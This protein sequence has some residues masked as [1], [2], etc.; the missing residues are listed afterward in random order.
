[1]SGKTIILLADGT[2]NGA[3]KLFKTNVWRLYKA[4]DLSEPPP[5][6]AKQQ[7]AYYH[8]GVGTSTFKPLAI[9]GGVFGFG[10]KRNVLHMYKFLCR[11][12]EPGDRIFVYGFSR[13][14]F[15]A[16][17]LSGVITTQGILSCPTE[18][19]LH[20]YAP[21]AYRWYRRRYKLPIF[22]YKDK[23]AATNPNRTVGLVDWLR[24]ARD[25]VLKAW[26]AAW[27]YKQYDSIRG[28]KY[29]ETFL[30]TDVNVD[31]IGV[32]D[33]VAAYGLPIDELTRGID[34]WVWPLSMPDYELS[35]RVLQARHA[36]S[37]DDERDTFHPLLWDEVAEADLVK[38]KLVKEGRLLQVWFAGMHSN[39]GGGYADD[40]LSYGALEWM[41][42]ESGKAGLFFLPQN[43]REAP[44]PR[45][46]F[47]TLYNSRSGV[48]AYYRYQP[49]K[50]AARLEHPDKTTLMMQ[51]PNRNGVGFL[52]TVTVHESVLHRVGTGDDCYAPIVLP[53]D[54]RVLQSNGTIVPGGLPKPVPAAPGATS[55]TEWVWNDVWRRRVNYF[56]T[57]GVSLVLA[58]LPLFH[59]LWP[60][61]ACSGPQCLL[62]PVITTAGE[63]LPGFVQPWIRAFSVSP[64]FFLLLALFIVLLLARSAYLKRCIQDGMRELWVEA[65]KLRK[66]TGP[67]PVTYAGRFP[68]G[69]RGGIY[70]LRSNRA[71]QTFFQWLKW[72]T[73]PGLFG[74]L[75]LI[76]GALIAV[77]LVVI[78]LQRSGMA[79]AERS[80]RYCEPGAATFSTA[81][82]CWVS[83]VDVKKGKRYVV[84]MRVT[85]DWLDSSPWLD[86]VVRTSPA[87]YEGGEMRWFA[88]WLVLARRSLTGRW[89]QVMARVIPSENQPSDWWLIRQWQRVFSPQKDGSGA[90][91]MGRGGHT[92]LLDMRCNCAQGPVYSAEFEAQRDGRVALFVNDAM[93]LWWPFTLLKPLDQDFYAN[94][95]GAAEVTIAQ[96]P[97]TPQ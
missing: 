74:A 95:Q 9:L 84:T 86:G 28:K 61:T 43:M 65:L 38:R 1:M 22:G 13:G 60:P 87:G 27:R 39:V 96:V 97:D 46:D 66:A 19:E 41:M 57:V 79:L 53:D 54:F 42:A 4:L 94:N 31:F 90:W 77:S 49:R 2:G 64:G 91:T 14:A 35:P 18:E 47:G 7:M 26:R 67:K 71:Y 50:I 73:L 44:T 24:N 63:F 52:K 69:P 88:R 6:G 29:P 68:T 89:D 11:N 45:D 48:G 30:H 12:Y 80:N 62:A 20:R 59:S 5:A 17:V 32:W 78:A 81:A 10:L 16:R 82:K 3:A 92:Q 36:L 83:G 15:T 56:M 33:T 72:R 8:D 21:D 51:D 40:S 55:R 75:V 70:G 93:P 23:R 85:Q 76:V 34:D 58:L 25:L 37:L